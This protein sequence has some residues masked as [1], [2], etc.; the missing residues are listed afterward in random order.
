[1]T[2]AGSTLYLDTSCFLKLFFREPESPRVVEVLASET[3]VVVSTLGRL[4][5]E[6]QLNSR[7][8][9]GH[10]SRAK[11][12]RLS[13]ELARTLTL[14]PFILAPFPADGFERAGALAMRAK[15]HCRT[16]DLLHL[17]V[18]DEA[19]IARLFTNDNVQA[20]VAR[21]LGILVT[22]PRQLGSP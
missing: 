3:Q 15:V 17:A 1:V 13:E 4:E 7:L 14:E 6:T 22:L 19:G 12:R 10:L 21:A 16:L 8:H 20:S 18:M 2:A 9:G 11:H 5:A